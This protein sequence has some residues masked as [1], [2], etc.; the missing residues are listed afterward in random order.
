M[1]KSYSTH[2]ENLKGRR[3]DEVLKD[4][5][6][7]ESFHSTQYPDVVKYVLEAMQ[8]ID[9]SYSYKLFSAF[10]RTQDIITQGLR[11]KGIEV[12]VRYTGPHNAE[13]HIEIYGCLLYTSPSPRDRTRTRMPSSA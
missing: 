10:R 12:D 6:V 7:S 3:Y 13:S 1:N 8:E 5:I 11:K 4:S 2:I 9:P